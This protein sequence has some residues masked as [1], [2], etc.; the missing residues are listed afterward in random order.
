MDSSWD[1]FRAVVPFLLGA[2]VTTIQL[3]AVCIVATL[4][5]ATIAGL[6]R[7]STN[8]AIRLIATVY[9]ELFR[10][11]SLLVQVFFIFFVLPAFGLQLERFVS[12]VLAISLGSSAYGS[13]IV[14]SSILA[15]EPGQWDA[16]RSVH[17][18]H[19][20]AMRRVILPQA[21]V[22]ALP[23]LGNLAI[24]I[25]KSTPLVS[26]I[27]ITEITQTG[28]SLRQTVANPHVVFYVM[29]ALYFAMGYPLVLVTRWL[30]KRTGRGLALGRLS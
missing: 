28:M 20:L 18:S 25:L 23:A 10:G 11:T 13:E 16:T 4:V 7:L 22:I 29:F 30:E 27:G 8:R 19:W 21:V 2:A 3:T 26:V 12:G 6:A 17:M 24:E 14:R 1:T 9:V 15:I 5:L